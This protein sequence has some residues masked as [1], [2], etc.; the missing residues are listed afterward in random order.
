MKHIVK[1]V[2]AGRASKDGKVLSPT[3]LRAYRF[4]TKLF[5]QFETDCDRHLRNPRSVL[6]ALIFHWLDATPA[7]QSAIAEKYHQVEGLATKTAK[8]T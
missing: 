6:E 4:D 1:K 7:Q 8:R 3:M 5:R 2:A